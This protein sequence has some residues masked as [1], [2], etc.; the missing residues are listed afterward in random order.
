M[1]TTRS[2]DGT[3]IAFDRAGAGP[4]LIFVGGGLSSRLAAGP[5]AAL[6]A[7]HFSVFSY[8]RRGRSNSGDT[9]P[10]AVKREEEDLAAIIAAAGGSAGVY[11]HSSGAV[12]TLEAA[13]RGLAMTRLAL[14]EPPLIVDHSRPLPPPDIMAQLNT[15]L[16]AGRRGDAVELFLTRAVLMPAAVVAQMQNTPAWPAMQALAHTIP[17]DMAITAG[18][19]SGEPAALAHWASVTMPALVLDGGAS[20]AWARHAVELLAKTMPHAQQRTL[21]DQTHG[22]DPRVLA[23]VLEEFFSE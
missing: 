15:L 1:E 22:A 18:Y 9:P 20:P 21:A 10:Y 7:P 19:Q 6:L 23:P 8:D 17:Y 16:A 4:A 2:S 11:G 3:A 14:Y 5:L 13:A 12:L